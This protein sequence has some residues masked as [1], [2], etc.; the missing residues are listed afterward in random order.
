MEPEQ[1]PHP[2]APHPWCWSL[3]AALP[4]VYVL[5]MAPLRACATRWDASGR[6]MEVL[7]IVGKPLSFAVTHWD[8]KHRWACRYQM[9]WNRKIGRPPEEMI[10]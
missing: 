7:T 1:G 2:R 6:S 10:F 3:L 8:Q 4:V 9:W 5:G